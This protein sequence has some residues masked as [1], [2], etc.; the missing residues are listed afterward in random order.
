[1]L[2]DCTIAGVTKIFPLLCQLLFPD[3]AGLRA[4]HGK[5]PDV[6]W[7]HTDGSYAGSYEWGS[8][9][10]F[11]CHFRCWITFAVYSAVQ[12]NDLFPHKPLS[13]FNT[14]IT[15]CCYNII[16]P[17][18]RDE[19]VIKTIC[20]TLIFTLLLGYATTLHLLWKFI[21]KWKDDDWQ[22]KVKGKVVLVLNQLSTT[23]W[24]LMGERMYRSTFSW[25]RP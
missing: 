21:T 14:I 18:T 19:S 4:P 11:P 2:H 6:F 20:V 25:P 12:N 13:G 10:I 23:P 24:K 1:M 15:V 5:A 16:S 22:C 3:S 9:F 17:L 8:F 7:R